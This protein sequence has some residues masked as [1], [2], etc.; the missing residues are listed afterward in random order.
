MYATDATMKGRIYFLA[1]SLRSLVASA[2]VDTAQDVGQEA[3]HTA[4]LLLQYTEDMRPALSASHCFS[5]SRQPL[6]QFSA[7]TH[8]STH[9]STQTVLS[10]SQSLPNTLRQEDKLRSQ[11]RL[12]S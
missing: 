7:Q 6:R 4:V 9:S 11:S 5:A 10:L 2:A 1:K 8:S 12:Q 3:S